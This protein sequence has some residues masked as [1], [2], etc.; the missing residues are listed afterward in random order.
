MFFSAMHIP[1]YQDTHPEK[2]STQEF[3]HPYRPQSQ[4]QSAGVGAAAAAFAPCF[5]QC[6]Q[7]DFEGHGAS[8]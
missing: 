5:H 3:H 8:G 2:S 4:L 7:Q 6:V 1:D